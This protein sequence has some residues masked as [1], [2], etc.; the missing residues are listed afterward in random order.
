MRDV[1]RLLEDM[2]TL[3][4]ADAGNG[5]LAFELVDLV[6]VFEAICVKAPGLLSLRPRPVLPHR[7]ILETQL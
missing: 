1:S 7:L 6:E 5:H 3:A 4:P 2:L